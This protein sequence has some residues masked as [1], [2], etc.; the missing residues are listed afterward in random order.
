MSE[1]IHASRPNDVRIEEEALLIDRNC[2]DTLDT[3]FAHRAPL[4]DVVG[5]ANIKIFNKLDTSPLDDDNESLDVKMVILHENEKWRQLLLAREIAVRSIEACMGVPAELGDVRDA[6]SHVTGGTLYDQRRWFGGGAPGEKQLWKSIIRAQEDGWSLAD[7]LSQARLKEDEEMMINIFTLNHRHNDPDRYNGSLKDIRRTLEKSL[8]IGD[9]PGQVLR[10]D[11]DLSVAVKELRSVSRIK[12][13]RDYDELSDLIDMGET[14]YSRRSRPEQN[15]LYVEDD[16][17]YVYVPSNMDVYGTVPTRSRKSSVAKTSLSPEQTAKHQAARRASDAEKRVIRETEI[18]EHNEEAAQRNERDQPAIDAM[19]EIADAYNTIVD[20]Y[21][22]Q[23]TRQL[24]AA[25]IFGKDSL[26]FELSK[27]KNSDPA[28]CDR[29]CRV[30]SQL[31]ALA[32]EHGDEAIDILARDLQE[33]ERL[34]V[35]FIEYETTHPLE[36]TRA[37]RRPGESIKAELAWLAQNWARFRGA[38][39]DSSHNQRVTPEQLLTVAKLIGADEDYTTPIDV[40]ESVEQ[41]FED[42]MPVQ[43]MTNDVPQAEE[44]EVPVPDVPRE[45]ILE[46]VSPLV[47]ANRLAEQLSWVVL[48]SDHISADDLVDIA[49]EVVKKRAER[50]KTRPEVEKERMEALLRLRDEFGGT[51]YRSDERTL[52]DSDNLYFVLRFQH[53]GDDNHYAVAENPVY[54][55]ATYVLRED[56]LPL[57]PGESVLSA[58]RLERKEIS[59]FGAK[60]IIHTVKS[61]DVHTDKVQDSLV[62]LSQLESV[63]G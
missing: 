10:A 35:Q 40:V 36:G 53:P 45:V 62:K 49:E 42:D 51:L 58:L 43:E 2:P 41:V 46:H 19:N 39:V 6:M 28:A 63:V 20:M 59:Y 27:C 56:T 12:R 15:Q 24:R 31:R 33:L 5:E 4:I 14:L 8:K 23:T 55:N 61:A 13:P 50:T 54:G 26:L 11:L 44:A 16:R 18:Q 57:Q 37:Y 48:P 32:I 7:A 47:M 3:A 38:L 25:A 52:G 9:G 34:A 29:V 17:R 1:N 22:G 30:Y 21:V 60:R